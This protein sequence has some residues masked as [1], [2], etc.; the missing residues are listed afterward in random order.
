MT[1]EVLSINP[2]TEIESAARLMVNRQVSGLPVVED[3]RPVGIVS[4]IDLVE[5]DRSR[6]APSDEAKSSAYYTSGDGSFVSGLEATVHAS[7]PVRDIMTPYV[8]AVRAEESINAAAKQMT[9][10]RVHRLLVM[11]GETLVGLVSSLDLLGGF[12]HADG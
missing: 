4:L 2:D 5:P 6:S 8:I 1:R 7:G 3:G 10:Y 12:L 9:E 11:D